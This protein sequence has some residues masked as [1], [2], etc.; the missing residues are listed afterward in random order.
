MA[1]IILG[2]ES[3]KHR[4][5]DEKESITKGEDFDSLTTLTILNTISN[6]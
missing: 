5:V 1:T 3:Y 4:P 2:Y 6:M